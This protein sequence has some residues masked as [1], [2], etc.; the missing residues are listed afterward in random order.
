[1]NERNFF[2][3]LKRRNVTFDNLDGGTLSLLVDPFLRSLHDDPRYKNLLTRL[4]L[5]PS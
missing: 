4:E 5:P 1:M 2:A 3:E